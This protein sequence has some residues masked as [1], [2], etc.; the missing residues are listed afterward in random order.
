M[1]A[2]LSNAA[3]TNATPVDQYRR[4]RLHELGHPMSEVY[5]ESIRYSRA[6]PPT[7]TYDYSNP[8]RDTS[9]V[10]RSFRLQVEPG[11][12]P[13]TYCASLNVVA[14]NASVS[15]TTRTSEEPQRRRIGGAAAATIASLTN[16]VGDAEG[17]TN[18]P[19][20]VGRMLGSSPTP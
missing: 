10:C 13:T 1:R 6:G 18:R 4:E 9:S 17:I 3:A 14:F 20:F 19:F 5:F 12:A 2:G 8:S 7:A 16:K 15:R 11:L